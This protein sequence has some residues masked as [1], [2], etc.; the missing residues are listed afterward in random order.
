[1]N[2]STLEEA[3]SFPSN[4][5]INTFD[6]YASPMVINS[7]SSLQ[8]PSPP[9]KNKTSREGFSTQ[10]TKCDAILEHLRTCE[11][12]RKLAQK[13]ICPPTPLDTAYETVTPCIDAIRNI[14][15]R[16]R[17]QLIVVL[18]AICFALFLFMLFGGR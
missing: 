10:G 16:F 3:W 1:M 9:V 12:C 6:P 7:S 5:P 15:P 4:S 17:S 18:L 14:S 13:M 8:P 2:Y 11:S